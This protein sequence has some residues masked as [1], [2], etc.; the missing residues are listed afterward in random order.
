MS[1]ETAHL[2]D[3]EVRNI[4]D[5]NYSR[6]ETILREKEDKLHTM[7]DALMRFETID[8]NQINDIMEGREPRPPEDWSDSDPTAGGGESETGDQDASEDSGGEIGGPASQH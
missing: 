2:I 7:A 1:D 4:V 8:T 3:E 6:A 5:R